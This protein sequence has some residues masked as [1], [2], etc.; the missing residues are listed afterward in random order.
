MEQKSYKR[1]GAETLAK[2]VSAFELSHG[3]SQPMLKALAL[4]FFAALVDFPAYRRM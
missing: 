1:R 2:S 3:Q 4:S